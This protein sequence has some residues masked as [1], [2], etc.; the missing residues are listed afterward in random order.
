M[1]GVNGEGAIPVTPELAGIAAAHLGPR[2]AAVPEER[3]K[4]MAAMDLLITGT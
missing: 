2:S 4:I 3:L 1:I